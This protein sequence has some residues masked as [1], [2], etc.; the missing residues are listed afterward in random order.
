LIG[1]GIVVL[2]AAGLYL[3]WNSRSALDEFWRPVREASAPVLFG[4]S[5]GPRQNGA[6]APAEGPKT[7]SDMFRARED[8]V[9][10]GDVSALVDL[11][12]YMRAKGKA[13]HLQ[14]ASM[15][16]FP[17]LKSGPA[18]LM[19]P[20]TRW[21][22]QLASGTRFSVQRDE[23]VTRTWISDRQNPLKQLWSADVNARAASTADTYALITRIR[24]ESTRQILVSI[25][26]LSPYATSAAGELLED[27][28]YLNEFGRSRMGDWADHN[29]QFVLATKR[30]GTTPGA[31]RIVAYYVW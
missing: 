16:T 7:L 26:G 23:A 6:T 4:V 15:V 13:Y 9:P 30:V 20:T 5:G 11:A 10:F 8:Y 18:V 3:S 14:Y 24:L 2:V 25:A 22:E 19:G 21:F 29:L 1:L 17:D 31:P 28:Q 12:G 27:P